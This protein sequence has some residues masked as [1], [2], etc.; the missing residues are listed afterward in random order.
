MNA[1]EAK[2]WISFAEKD[3]SAASV[4]LDSGEFFPRQI[5][6]LAQQAA[7]KAIKAVLVFEEV[8]FPK[9][10]DLDRLRD[11]IPDGWIV[12]GTFP[13]LAALTIWA[14]ESRY[15]GDV[16]DVV[17][18]EARETLSLAQKVYE[19]IIEEMGKRW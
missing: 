19:T 7:E 8:D 10:H 3:L 2:R 1:N 4:L 6:F 16:P 5:C 11:L 14:V 13:D 12:K 17:E 15:P 18:A 9:N